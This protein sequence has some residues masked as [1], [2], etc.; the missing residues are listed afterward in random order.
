MKVIRGAICAENNAESISKNSVFLVEQVLKANCL[1]ADDIEC[2]FF[3]A[4]PDL[5]SCYPATAVRKKLLPHASFMCFSEMFTD[6][7]LPKVIRVAVFANKDIVPKHCYIGE[8]SAL[9]PDLK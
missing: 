5:T 8:A 9:R 7:S 6:G 3:S 2:V 4:T 1:V